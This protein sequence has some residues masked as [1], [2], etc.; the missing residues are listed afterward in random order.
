MKIP[1]LC[2]LFRGWFCNSLHCELYKWSDE[3]IM[4]LFNSELI[5]KFY[6]LEMCSQL[7]TSK[8]CTGQPKLTGCPLL[9]A[10]WN[11]TLRHNPN[12]LLNMTYDWFYWTFYYLCHLFAS[13]EHLKSVITLSLV[14]QSLPCCTFRSM[15]WLLTLL[16]EKQ[17][18]ITKS[19]Q[20]TD[21][22]SNQEDRCWKRLGDIDKSEP[23]TKQ[24]KME[25]MGCYLINPLNC[26][27]SM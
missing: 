5:W 17:H 20:S 19:R 26:F 24:G 14:S 11:N 13:C 23:K 22:R 18:W 2:S 16:I 4:S 6:Y 12:Q 3:E 1:H 10:A 7:K 27:I 15:Q 8:N 21:S 9:K 25:A